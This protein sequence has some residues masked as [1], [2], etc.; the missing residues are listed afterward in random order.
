MGRPCMEEL[1]SS[2]CGK[3]VQNYT[4]LVPQEVV[5]LKG[6]MSLQIRSLWRE[7]F[8]NRYFSIEILRSG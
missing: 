3:I 2:Q 5:V 7:T 4:Y 6:V 8:N 1:K